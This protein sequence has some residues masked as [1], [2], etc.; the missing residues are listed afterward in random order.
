MGYWSKVNFIGMP[1]QVFAI[2]LYSNSPFLSAGEKH[3]IF[4]AQAYKET[5]L[6]GLFI[7]VIRKYTN[8]FFNFS[9]SVHVFA[10]ER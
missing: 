7:T 9:P 2:H 1:Q 10:R 4:V 6:F 8:I 3:W 5:C